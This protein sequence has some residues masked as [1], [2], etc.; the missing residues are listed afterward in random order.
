MESPFIEI[1]LDFLEIYFCM[2]IRM[3]KWDILQKMSIISQNRERKHDNNQ[4]QLW[5]VKNHFVKKKIKINLK[6]K[7]R[8]A[9]KRVPKQIDSKKG[10]SKREF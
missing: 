7:A 1:V 9:L 4:W 5:I 10:G 3:E 2:K 6:F 8:E